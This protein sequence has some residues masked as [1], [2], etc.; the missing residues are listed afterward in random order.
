MV[1]GLLDHLHLGTG[2]FGDLD[3]TGQGVGHVV[4]LGVDLGPGG[5]VV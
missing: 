3:D 1:R 5:D 4:E 2:L